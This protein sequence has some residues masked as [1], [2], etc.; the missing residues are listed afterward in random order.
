M[1]EIDNYFKKQNSKDGAHLLLQVHDELVFEIEEKKVNALAPKIQEIM[2]NIVPEKDRKGIP[3]ITEG[4]AGD[5][6]G[7]MQK[8]KI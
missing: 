7:E 6:W 1:V 3:F 2:E 4:K 8:I 5:N